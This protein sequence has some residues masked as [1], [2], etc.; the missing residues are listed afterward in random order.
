MSLYNL[1]K[2]KI[3]FETNSKFKI[4]PHISESKLE[5]EKYLSNYQIYF[6]KIDFQYSNIIV[7]DLSDSTSFDIYHQLLIVSEWLFN[8]GFSISGTFY[9]RI[10]NI[11]EYISISHEN[12]VFNHITLFEK[13]SIES[14]FINNTD[15]STIGNSIITDMFI[16]IKNYIH[17]TH[18][19]K[20]IPYI[21]IKNDKKT[22]NK[23]MILNNYLIAK[24][25]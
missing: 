21:N 10:N 22:F 4:E 7:D 8:H 6:W 1:Y 23:N 25:F 3:F 11:I 19:N 5:I 16:K 9:F 12:N 20:T 2:N 14:F 15:I 17:E 18:F 13:N 24:K